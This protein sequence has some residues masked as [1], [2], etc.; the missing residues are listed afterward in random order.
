M[1]FVPLSFLVAMLLAVFLIR[2]LRENP[3]A[4]QSHGLFV[5][6]IALHIVQSLLIGLRWGYGV[7]AVL[8]LLPIL[9]SLV[10]VLTFLAFRDLAREA[11]GVT[12]RDWPHLLPVL[13][14]IGF[15]F[16]W[17]LPLDLV[18]I[19]SFLGYGLALLWIARFGPDGLVA[20]RLDGSLRS[21]RAL[22]LTAAALILS[23]FTDIAI[24]LDMTYAAGR[25]S[26]MVVSAAT[27]LILLLLG[28]GAA[29]AG[30]SE[31]LQ[32]GPSGSTTTAAGGVDHPA[33]TGANPI[34]SPRE[35][36]YH[37]AARLDALMADR[38]LFADTDLNLTRLARRL[39]V[40]ARAV[41]EAVN[42][43]HGI[44]V[45]HYVNNQRV[46]EACR[47]LSETEMP[48]TCILFEAGFMTKSNFN[49][50]FLRVTGESPTDWRRRMSLLPSG[51]TVAQ[52]AG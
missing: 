25:N 33:Q 48:I 15:F 44:S 34:R 42:R 16:T 19:A 40:P 46:K 41:S 32:E 52:S 17:R 51:E 2:L 30:Q 29:T 37:L 21:Y 35:D 10:P 12:M 5:R 14:C 27:T 38:R 13:A 43:V 47:L 39:A 7:E 18:L 11:S 36:E 50:E 22:L 8:W 45:S 6:L 26:P 4:W 3:R 49:R 23:A 1:I 9:A 24:S 31:A 20:S 28:I